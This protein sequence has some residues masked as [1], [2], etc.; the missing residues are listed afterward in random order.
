MPTLL[1]VLAA[2]LLSGALPD[3]A[4]AGPADI[5]RIGL[6]DA[7]ERA[8][9]DI[10]APDRFERV[11]KAL[12]ELEKSRPKDPYVHWAR[13]RLAFFQRDHVTTHDAD[14]LT[15]DQLEK[16][17]LD[18][19]ETCHHSADRCIEVDP[20]SP[21]CFMMKGSCY[22]MQASTWGVGIKSLRVCRP[23]E[24]AWQ[25]AVELPSSFP[26]EKGVTTALLSRTLLAILYRVM[27]ESF[28]FRFLAGTRGN[29]ERAYQ[30]LRETYRS[31]L[32]SEPMLT[33]EF[34]AAAICYG[35]RAQQPAAEK[36]GLEALRK[37][38]AVPPRSKGDEFDIRNM[39]Y[40]LDNPGESCNYRREKFENLSDDAIGAK[41]R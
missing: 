33:M 21:E 20:K 13:A 39:R 32:G 15:A 1:F 16:V 10:G 17:R 23:M 9:Y 8:F 5:P 38:V 31:P 34:A 7:A 4:V 27:P 26:H 24:L 2:F 28:W 35:K 29:K 11:A 19:A 3:P 37:A 25:K 36:E 12:D 6:Y 30:W 18:L 14:T 40:L 41:V 22:A